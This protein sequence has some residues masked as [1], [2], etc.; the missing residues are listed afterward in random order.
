MAPRD[1]RLLL[2]GAPPTSQATQPPVGALALLDPDSG[3]TAEVLGHGHG[4]VPAGIARDILAG[5]DGKRW[6]RRLF[7]HPTSGAVIDADPRRRFFDGVMAKLI[8]IRDGDRCTDAFCDAA[9][10]NIDHIHT[11]RTDGPTSFVNGR[12]TCERGNQV[13][14]MPGWT[15]ELVHDG[16]GDHPHTVRTTTPTGHTYTSRAGP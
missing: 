3:E 2:T 11:A 9:A 6:L 13:R 14:E 1:G 4:P 5:T 10:R 7:A 8:R 12:A 16:L 15:V